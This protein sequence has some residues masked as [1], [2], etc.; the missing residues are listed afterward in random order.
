MQLT[1][2]GTGDPVP[3]EHDS[4]YRLDATI[5]L[6][7]DMNM[8][9][10]VMFIWEEGQRLGMMVFQTIISKIINF[11]L[12]S[13]PLLHIVNLRIT[14]GSFPYRFKLANVFPFYKS[15]YI[16]YRNNFCP[17]SLLSVFSKIIEKFIKD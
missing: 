4:E 8:I 5:T 3:V 11:K 6:Q 7:T 10:D 16:T 1:Q 13:K 9:Y 14:S 12:I 15:N 2:V 17:I